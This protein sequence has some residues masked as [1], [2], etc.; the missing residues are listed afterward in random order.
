MK[1]VALIVLCLALVSPLQA[2]VGEGHQRATRLAV[3]LLPDEMPAFFRQ[4]GE[5]LAHYSLDPD[6]VKR[7]ELKTLIDA[8]Y[9]EHFFD[10]EYLHG[11]TLPETRT[12]Y[13]WLCV[14]SKVS[15]N[16]AGYLPY[17][18]TE[19][20]QRLTV[21]FA[22]YRKWPGNPAI[23]QKCLYLAGVLAHYAQDLEMPLHLTVHYDGRVKKPGD[24]SPRSGIHLKVDRLIGN[25]EVTDRA[26]LKD[27]EPAAYGKLFDSVVAR[28]EAN[29]KLV[30]RVYELEKH[31]PEDSRPIAG[32]TA[33]GRFAIDRLR[34]CTE[35]TAN[36]YLTAWHDSKK[37]DLPEWHKR[38]DRHP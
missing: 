30:D 32:G 34:G 1:R 14:K 37:I 4:G 13:I 5:M 16:K 7:P 25:V 3:K 28:I 18:V 38:N 29:H 8:E 36:L 11:K 17:A 15:P 2:W 19:Y 12:G 33:L 6:V 24:R 23:R 26:V 22:E 20:T 10:I 35:F 31:L 27:L 9:P 21:A